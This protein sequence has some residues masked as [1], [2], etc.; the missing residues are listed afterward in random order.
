MQSSS[1]TNRKCVNMP[2]VSAIDISISLGFSPHSSV[3]NERQSYLKCLAWATLTSSISA[4]TLRG[5]CLLKESSNLNHC[6]TKRLLWNLE[7]YRKWSVTSAHQRIEAVKPKNTEAGIIVYLHTT[8]QWNIPLAINNKNSIK[9]KEF[10]WLN[11]NQTDWALDLPN[12]IRGTRLSF[13]NLPKA[14][15]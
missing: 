15:S 5:N 11:I 9:S 10:K 14:F 8:W 1:R 2:A 12:L 3:L 6:T 7:S 4:I 13:T